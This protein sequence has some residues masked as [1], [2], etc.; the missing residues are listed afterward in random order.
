MGRLFLESAAITC[1]ILIALVASTSAQQRTPGVKEGDWFKF[2]NISANWYSN[3]PN[4]KPPSDVEGYNGVQ[5][6]FLNISTVS[7]TT[8]ICQF[9]F[10]YKNGTE[11]SA[12]GGWVDIESGSG[13]LAPWLISANLNTGETVYSSGS[14]TLRINE[15]ILSSYPVSSREANHVRTNIP[16]NATGYSYSQDYYW[17]RTTGVLLENYFEDTN[18][19]GSHVMTSSLDVKITDSNVW[20]VPEFPFGA[21]TI[22]I[23][24]TISV[25]ILIIKQPRRSENKIPQ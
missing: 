15:T 20:T 24:T 1:L 4:A 9:T 25:I 22:L 12:S 6:L 14:S 19:T 11:S 16:F 17:D 23:F 18:Y 2:G 13:N 10:H 21:S 5:W 8:V 7:E 3:D